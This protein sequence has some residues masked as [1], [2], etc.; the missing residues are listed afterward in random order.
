VRVSGAA[1]ADTPDAR[2]QLLARDDAARVR[3]QVAEQL[4]PALR[5]PARAVGEDDLL[6]LEVHAALA[7]AGAHV[8]R[9]LRRAAEHG[10]DA[11]GSSRMLNG[12]VT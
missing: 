8:A 6:A 4:G 9:P 7:G 2:E 11:R 10:V 1:R 3:G 5:A 12:F